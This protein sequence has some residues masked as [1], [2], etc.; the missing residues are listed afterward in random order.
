RRASGRRLA[1]LHRLVQIE[2]SHVRTELLHHLPVQ[3][4]GRFGVSRGEGEGLRLLWVVG[5]LGSG[6]CEQ[7][8]RHHQI[9]NG[10]GQGLGARYHGLVRKGRRRRDRRLPVVIEDTRS[11]RR[12]VEDA[13][14]YVPGNVANVV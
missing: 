6:P 2:L 10:G 14:R 11:A 8:G 4:Q 1:E 12:K 7:I 9:Q 13:G 3:V 5:K